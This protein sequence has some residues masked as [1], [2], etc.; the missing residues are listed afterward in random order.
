MPA[1]AEFS[2]V[3]PQLVLFHFILFHL[4]HFILF[5]FISFSLFW[6][7]YLQFKLCLKTNIET[8]TQACL[9]SC[10][11]TENENCKTTLF[12]QTY[13]LQKIKFLFFFEQSACFFCPFTCSWLLA[14]RE[15]WRVVS[16]RIEDVSRLRSAI[17]PW[18]HFCNRVSPATTCNIDRP[19]KICKDFCGGLKCSN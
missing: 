1:W 2:Q 16:N 19:A 12:S 8:N 14:Y 3:Q 15:V 4:F 11:T 18:G 17:P 5:Y 7:R 6:L 10:S 9:F 13:K